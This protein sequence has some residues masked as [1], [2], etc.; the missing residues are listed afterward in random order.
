MSQSA[1]TVRAF[2]MRRMQTAYAA[3]SSFGLMLCRAVC[4]L[5]LCTVLA[6]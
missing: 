4:G 1:A 2:R 3:L 5:E 6:F